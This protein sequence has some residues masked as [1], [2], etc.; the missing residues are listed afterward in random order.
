[1]AYIT[2]M[3]HIYITIFYHLFSSFDKISF[4]IAVKI[5]DLAPFYVNITPK[6]LAHLYILFLA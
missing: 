5:Y 4:I 3:L 2:K 6:I 1:M